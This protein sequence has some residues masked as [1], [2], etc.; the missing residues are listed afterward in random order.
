LKL[1]KDKSID[2]TSLNGRLKQ[3]IKCW[4]EIGANSYI[5]EVIQNAYIIPFIHTP[6]IYVYEKQH[7]SSG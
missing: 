1:K 3:N 4:E 2:K 6:K 7:I 5:K